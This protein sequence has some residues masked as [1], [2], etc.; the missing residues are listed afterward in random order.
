MLC[1]LLINIA[2]FVLNMGLLG[3]GLDCLWKGYR[4]GKRNET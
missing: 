1:A 3:Y 4:E 2:S